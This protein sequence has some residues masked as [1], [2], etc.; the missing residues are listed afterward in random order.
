MPSVRVANPDI[1][2]AGIAAIYRP[3]VEETLVSFEEVAPSAAEMAERIRSTLTWTPWLVASDDD[4]V[5][6]GYAYASRHRERAGYRWSVDISVYVDGDW[7]RRGVGRALYAQLLPILERQGF[8]NMYAGITVPNPGSVRL[9]ESIGMRLIG[10]YEHVGFKFGEWP[11]VAWY[12]MILNP[13]TSSPAEPIALTEF[14]RNSNTG[15]A[16]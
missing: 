7:Q 5:V 2:G 9:H 1:D 8:V 12:G 10:V 15:S 13:P 4:G 3:Y 16:K 11:D 14:L 6:V